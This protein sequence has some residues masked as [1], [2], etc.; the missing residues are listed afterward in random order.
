MRR[1]MT[2]LDR[3]ALFSTYDLLALGLLFGLWAGIGWRVEHPSVRHPS[4][5]LL[6]AEYRRAWMKELVTREPRVFDAQVLGT[7]RQ[8]TAFFASTCMIALGGTFAMI[9]NAEQLASVAEDIT[10]TDHPAIIWEFKLLVLTFFLANA[11]LKFVWANRLFGYCSVLIAAVPNDPDHPKAYHRAAQA[12][13]LNV[14]AARSFNKGQRSIYFALAAAAWLAGPVALG[15]AT[16]ITFFV[17][18]RREFW[19][20]SRKILLDA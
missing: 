11:F 4:T 15:L 14:T 20:N 17:V 18:W 10:L 5:A 1:A 9:G 12:A 13:E 19:S 7:L 6:M 3:F 2:F 16:V 8:G